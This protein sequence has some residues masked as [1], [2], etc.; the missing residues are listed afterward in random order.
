MTL[1]L[2]THVWLWA[3]EAPDKLG[4]RTKALLLKSGND[5]RFL[6]F[7]SIRPSLHNPLLHHSITPLLHYPTTPFLHPLLHSSIPPFLHSSI[8]RELV[9]NLPLRGNTGQIDHGGGDAVIQDPDAALARGCILPNEVR[10]TGAEEV[11]C[12]CHMPLNWDRGEIDDRGEDAVSHDPDSVLACGCIL[13]GEARL[14]CTEEV[15]RS[16]DMPLNW[17]RRK[18]DN[19]GS[20]AVI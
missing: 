5:P 9:Y 18:I 4:R 11:C 8:T 3:V 13:P 20:D 14:A 2:D 16:C 17:D 10:L 1:L 12:S 15:C 6:F 19:R 7:R